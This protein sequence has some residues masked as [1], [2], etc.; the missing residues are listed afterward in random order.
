MK[1]YLL[2]SIPKTG[3]KGQIVEVS[4]G[5]GRYLMKQ[6]QATGVTPGV[7]QRLEKEKAREQQTNQKELEKI[8]ELA[9]R[10]DGEEIEV[11][12]SNK[13]GAFYAALSTK[14]IAKAIKSELG[15]NIQ[16]DQIKLKKPIKEAGDYTITI[17][18]K[19]GLEAELKLIVS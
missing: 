11:E 5:F 1:V 16:P 14:E 19:H 10:I 2:E 9:G 8:Q 17:A 12:A 4:E 13:S 6:K 3:A 7:V 18:F 15:V